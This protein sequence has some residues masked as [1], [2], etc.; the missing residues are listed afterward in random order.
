[1]SGG[2]NHALESEIQFVQ[3]PCDN[4]DRVMI[5]ANIRD[6]GVER[7][8][9]AIASSQKPVKFLG[10]SRNGIGPKGARALASFLKTNRTVSGMNLQANQLQDE[11]VG[12]LAAALICNNVMATLHLCNNRIGH[13][14]S[15]HLA[16][17]LKGT[18]SLRLLTLVG[19]DIGDVGVAELASSLGPN[20]SLHTLN[21]SDNSMSDHGL[22]LLSDGLYQNSKPE[23][24]Y[25]DQCHDTTRFTESAFTMFVQ[26][27]AKHSAVTDLHHRMYMGIVAHLGRWRESHSSKITWSNGSIWTRAHSDIAFDTVEHT[28]ARSRDQ[29][30]LEIQVI[31]A[32]SGNDVCVARA[33]RASDLKASIHEAVGIPVSEQ[34]LFVDGRQLRHGEVL[35]DCLT[36]RDAVVTL[37]HSDPQGEATAISQ[38]SGGRPLLEFDAH[39]RSN[40]SVV[41]AAVKRSGSNFEYAGADLRR[42]REFVLEAV[43]LRGTALQ[44]AAEY[45]KRDREIVLAAVRRSGFALQYASFDLQHDPEMLAASRRRGGY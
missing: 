24:L 12:F 32:I 18:C 28:S 5:N 17:M 21:L 27:V 42:D 36:G 37:L 13:I 10:L 6:R 30:P 29:S 8:V 22:R 43:R 11:G 39:L 16:A 34:Q 15:R 14:G 20:C 26:A 31:N 33:L 41:L 1:M 44:H 25:V 45:L 35:A 2:T 38:V 40:R 23:R 3:D 7:L 19:N 9:H 4:S